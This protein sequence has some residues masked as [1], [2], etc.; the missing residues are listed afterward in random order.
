MAERPEALDE[1]NRRAPH[2]L[3][4]SARYD[5]RVGMVQSA[6]RNLLA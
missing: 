6:F 5:Q 4:L 3:L 1:R 2:A